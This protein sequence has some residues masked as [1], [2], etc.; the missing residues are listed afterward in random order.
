MSEQSRLTTAAPGTPDS[1]FEFLD[2]AGQDGDLKL[3]T[4]K[5]LRNATFRVL[6]VDPRWRTIDLRELDLNE[7]IASFEEAR[8]DDYS[9]GSLKNYKSRFLQ[10]VEMYRAWLRGEDDWKRH[11]PGTRSPK[12]KWTNQL[13]PISEAV[14]LNPRVPAPLPVTPPPSL[15]SEPAPSPSSTRLMQH[16]YP[17]REDVDVQLQLP[18]DLTTVEANR[19]AKFISTLAWDET[20]VPV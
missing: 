10:T 2:M 6:S 13:T 20:E 19:L 5:A 18:R 11:G 14:E 1:A 16:T 17:L 8:S 15:A 9:P 4:V 3:D 12:F 7:Q